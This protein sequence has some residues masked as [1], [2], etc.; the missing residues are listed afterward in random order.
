MSAAAA[1][2]APPLCTWIVAA[3]L[4]ATCGADEKENKRIHGGGG[5]LFGTRR[6]LAAR[7]RAGARSGEDI[8]VSLSIFP[9]LVAPHPDVNCKLAGR[10]CLVRGI[11]LDS[12]ICTVSHR[13]CWHLGFQG[14]QDYSL[15]CA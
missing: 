5:G 8:S 4:S 14:R 7:R 3:C 6:H 11:G 12:G 15:F 9:W 1:A 2:V 10:M 13:L